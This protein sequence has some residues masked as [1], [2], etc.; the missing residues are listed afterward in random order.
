MLDVCTILKNIFSQKISETLQRPQI[1]WGTVRPGAPFWQLSQ[2]FSLGYLLLRN[3]ASVQR[4][5][6]KL[7]P[8]AVCACVGT[9]VRVC[10]RASCVFVPVCMCECECTCA[11]LCV[12]AVL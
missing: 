12:S 8:V 11:C 10:L 6:A 9:C 7:S 2:P 3:P 4:I 5:S 1:S